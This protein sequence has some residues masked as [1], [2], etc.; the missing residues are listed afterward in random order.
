[1]HL[2]KKLLAT[3]ALTVALAGIMPAGAATAATPEKTTTSHATLLN[4]SDADKTS[5]KDVGCGTGDDSNCL[6]YKRWMQATQSF[7]G[8][9]DGFGGMAA[10]SYQVQAGVSSSM[11]AAWSTW[12]TPSTS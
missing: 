10:T 6:P 12:P 9:F 1:M 2:W 11:M 4:T 3:A 8:R 7:H 5:W